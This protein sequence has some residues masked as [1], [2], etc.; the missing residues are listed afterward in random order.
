MIQPNFRIGIGIVALGRKAQISDML[1]VAV[2]GTYAFH[3][4]PRKEIELLAHDG[5][6]V[7]RERRPAARQ[8]VVDDRIE[9]S[10]VLE[11]N[12]ECCD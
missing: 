11:G 8:L 3:D 9:L 12:P 1:W 4:V 7:M 10:R 6:E 2:Q 5:D